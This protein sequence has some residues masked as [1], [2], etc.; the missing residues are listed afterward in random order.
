MYQQQQPQQ[1]KSAGVT[2]DDVNTAQL[3]TRDSVTPAQTTT[4]GQPAD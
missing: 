3:E 1:Q 2:T 4:S